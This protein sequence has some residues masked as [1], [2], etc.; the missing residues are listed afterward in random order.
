MAKD[1]QQAR[2]RLVVVDDHRVVAE[3]I[4]LHLE[5]TAGV[6]VVAVAHNADSGCKLALLR[7]ADLA[8]MDVGMPGRCSFDACREIVARSGG[9]T[10]V[11]L[12]AGC[13]RENYAD[14]ALE[15]G[16]GGIACKTTETMAELV[17]AIQS[18]LQGGRYVSPRWQSRLKSLES[19]AGLFGAAQLTSREVT[20]LSQVAEGR[21]A[22]ELAVEFGITASAVYHTIHRSREKLGCLTNEQLMVVAVREGVVPLVGSSLE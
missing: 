21:T 18:I 6:D 19:G 5:A 15:A 2:P 20:V 14:R 8:L 1:R 3:A 10:K 11:L 13:P 4:A 7:E 12:Y 22:S 16:A 17:A 9:K